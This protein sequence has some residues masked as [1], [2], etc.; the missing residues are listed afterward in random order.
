MIMRPRRRYGVA[1][2]GEDAEQS[3]WRRI[4]GIRDAVASRQVLDGVRSRT[5]DGRVD[6][7]LNGEALL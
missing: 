2:K 7:T 4:G 6:E 1:R 5:G 3:S